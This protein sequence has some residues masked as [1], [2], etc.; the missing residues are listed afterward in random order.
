MH[1]K[2]AVLLLGYAKVLEVP[3]RHRSEHPAVLLLACVSQV[4]ARSSSN[5]EPYLH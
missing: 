2:P 1:G 3:H 5:P 4:P